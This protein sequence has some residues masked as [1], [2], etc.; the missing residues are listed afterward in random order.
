VL[1]GN[2]AF[3]Q[4][5]KSKRKAKQLTEAESL[6]E[7][8]LFGHAL[9]EK[10]KGNVQGALSYFDQALEIDPLDAAAWYEK[11]NLFL[12]LNRKDEAL[13]AAKKAMEIDGKNKWYLVLYANASKANDRYDEYVKTYETLS[14]EYPND[15]DFLNELAFAYYYTG[16]YKKAIVAYDKIEDE[17]GV[18]EQLTTQKVSFYDKLKEPEKGVEEYQKLIDSN[19]EEPRYYALMAEYC[20]KNSLDDQAITAYK[21]IV[22]L[23]PNDPYVH[24]SLA[25]YYN[26][27]G[28]L[29]RSFEQLKLGLANKSLDLKTK[30]NVLVNYYQGNLTDVQK[31]HALE[32]SEVLMKAHP[33]EMLS[34]TFHASMLFENNE[35]EKARGLFVDILKD[36][37]NNYSIWEQLLLCDLNLQNFDLLGKDAEEAV[38]YFPNYPQP[39]FFAGLANLQ[40][41]DYVK[42]KAYL[43]S[44]KSF[45]VNNDAL[46]EQFYSTLGDTYYAL[47]NTDAAFESYDKALVINPKNALVLNNY[48][49]YLS[50]ET[51][52]LDK[53]ATM[54]KQAVDLDPYNSNNL[55]TYAWVLYK[56]GKYSEA[57]IWIEKA[58]D[59]KGDKSGVVL[60]HYG[61]I[62]F[63]LDRKDEAF[64]FWKAAYEKPEH[65][66]LLQKKITDKN[67]YE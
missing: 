50:L 15:L 37:T 33:D 7:A 29:D 62:L 43:E 52:N 19:P 48:A 51:K 6:H 23:N 18:N 61:D 32:L 67:L 55:D 41:K 60:E 8:D 14:Q 30:I 10:S 26:K 27:K 42:A 54:A 16:D 57:I 46:L 40:T 34:H 22:E 11:A 36:E 66:E 47:E 21:K 13:E 58:Y 35:F 38:D 39:Y 56:Q 1:A 31:K 3:A 2:T 64:D 12:N 44:G 24:I 63:R 65:S 53:A 59:N 25:D 17:I 45:V 49:Y 4:G 28:D 5:K 9:V 20:A